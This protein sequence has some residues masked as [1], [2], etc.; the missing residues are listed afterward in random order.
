MTYHRIY[1]FQIVFLSYILTYINNKMNLNKREIS[2]LSQKNY[3]LNSFSIDKF[4]MLKYLFYIIIHK[5]WSY[6]FHELEHKSLQFTSLN[7]IVNWLNSILYI[8]NIKMTYDGERRPPR[9][10]SLIL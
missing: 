7:Y 9:R 4:M 3:V 2:F 6:S 8:K 10:P 1:I 5:L